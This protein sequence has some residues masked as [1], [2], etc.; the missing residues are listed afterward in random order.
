[1]RYDVSDMG[2][3]WNPKKTVQIAFRVPEEEKVE[4]ERFARANGYDSLSDWIR[5]L[6]RDDIAREKG[7]KKKGN[8]NW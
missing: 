6:M 4:A 1:M 5:S 3:S 7:T 2:R 8:S